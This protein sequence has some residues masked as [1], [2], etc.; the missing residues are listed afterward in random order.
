MPMEKNVAGKAGKPKPS[1]NEL[2][3]RVKY[4]ELQ[5]REVEAKLRFRDAQAKLRAGRDD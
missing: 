1:M 3:D 2:E 4:A 5:A